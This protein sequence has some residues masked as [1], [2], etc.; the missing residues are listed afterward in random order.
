MLS[1]GGSSPLYW[2][3]LAS[4]STPLHKSAIYYS[5]YFGRRT[6]MQDASV[7]ALRTHYSHSSVRQSPHTNGCCRP[8]KHKQ[9]NKVNLR[10]WVTHQFFQS[11]TTERLRC[12][13]AST[14]YGFLLLRGLHLVVSFCHVLL[15]SLRLRC[16]LLV[17]FS[18]S[19]HDR[20]RTSSD[21]SM[22]CSS[23]MLHNTE[24]R[25]SHEHMQFGSLT[26]LSV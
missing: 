10:R 23:A 6:T 25:L 2:M 18:I 19:S 16:L 17:R 4:S 24:S 5:G 21:G 7:D 3:P 11:S 8:P 1:R 22:Q 15:F 20:G 13:T 12:F 9:R 14:D 26:P